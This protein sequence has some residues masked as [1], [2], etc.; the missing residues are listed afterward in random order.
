MKVE[1][2]D[3]ELLRRVQRQNQEQIIGKLLHDLRNPVHSMRVTVELFGRLTQ[4]DADTAALLTRATRYVGPAESAVA[5]LMRHTEQLSTYLNPPA[6][7][8][9]QPIAIDEWLDEIATLLT[10][11]TPGV[12]ASVEATLEGVHIAADRPRLSHALLRWCLSKADAP[13]VLS[14][15]QAEPE[16]IQI[17]AASNQWTRDR[18]EPP[19][20]L[21]ELERLID[22]AGGRLERE[23]SDGVVF[24]FPR[25]PA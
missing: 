7:P 24:S 5:A 10:E 1:V 4:Q 13:V 12:E 20:T 6:S 14:S 17:R 21:A 18:G 25:A 8:A 23:I 2:T 16:R 9:V 19:F 11:S 3:A 22:S 15:A